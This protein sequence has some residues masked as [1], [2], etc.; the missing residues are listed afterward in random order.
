MAGDPSIRVLSVRQAIAQEQI[1]VL[2]KYGD[3]QLSPTERLSILV[4]EV[5]EVA[6]CVNVA[7]VPPVDGERVGPAIDNLEYELA[8]VAACC[9]EWIIQLRKDY[10]E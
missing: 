10:P 2:A 6:E 7:F 3:S 8:Q 5:G 1:K 4:E 9:I